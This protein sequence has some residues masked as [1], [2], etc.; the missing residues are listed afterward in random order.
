[1][2]RIALCCPIDRQ[3]AIARASLD[4]AATLAHHHTVVVFGEPS[5]APLHCPVALHPLAAARP[6]AF[7]EFD[8]V[9]TVL[10]DSGFHRHALRLAIRRPTI[11][12]LHDVLLAHLV[13]SVLSADETVDELHRW[14]GADAAASAGATMATSQPFWDS[15]DAMRYPLFE[16]A[17][18]NASGVVVHSRFAA[19]HVLGKVICPVRAL[20]LAY[21]PGQRSAPQS[22]ASVDGPLLVTIGNANANKQHELVI[23]A[24]AHL[25]DS[26]VRYAIAGSISPER[27]ASLTRFAESTG[28]LAQVDILGPLSDEDL[29]DLLGRATVCMNLRDPVME[30]GSASL[31]EQMLA[32][33]PVVVFDHGCYADAP[34]GT[35]VKL[36]PRSPAQAV[37]RVVRELLD[38]GQRCVSLGARANRFAAEQHSFQQYAA[39]LV[40]F[41]DDVDAAAP[42]VRFANAV[43]SA[44]SSWGV[45]SDSPLAERWATLM[46]DM[47]EGPTSHRSLSDH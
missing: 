41:F 31:I 26:R 33:K 29:A 17:T 47:T 19:L 5:D 12:I 21:R 9:I 10:G 8:R 1:M 3:S 30:G 35:V 42:T 39:G 15:P 37:A 27:R 16:V 32:G 44:V 20:P 43:R 46:V 34:D 38:D 14:Y 11:V 25:G 22:D 2:S 40:E 45:P 24:M 36:A 6:E 23:E 7:D 13:V 4:L 28:V 18:A